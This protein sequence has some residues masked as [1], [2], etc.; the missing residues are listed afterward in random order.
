MT[1]LPQRLTGCEVLPPLIRDDLE[2]THRTDRRNG[3]ASGERR[4]KAKGATKNRKASADRFAVLNN[5]IDFTLAGLTRNELAV[6]LV[7]YRDSRDGIAR[8]SQA[9]IARRAGMS[10]RT[11]RRSLTK[12]EAAGLLKAVHRGGLNRGS[13]SYRVSALMNGS[14]ADKGLSGSTGQFDTKAADT[15]LSYIP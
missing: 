10:D 13:S 11:V 4:D 8:T 3:H 2:S 1:G 7:L 14:T 9:D 5:F 6:W 12:L 15:A